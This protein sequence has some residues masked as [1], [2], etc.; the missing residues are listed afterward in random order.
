MP[1]QLRIRSSSR[2]TVTAYHFAFEVEGW[3]I[4]TIN[5]D[6]GEISIQSDWGNYA[7]RWTPKHTG[8]PSMHHFFA[9]SG[10][11]YFANKFSYENPKLKNVPDE[12]RTRKELRALIIERRKDREIGADE[13]R[14]L[15]EHVDSFVS[16]NCNLHC[17]DRELWKFLDEPWEY[18]HETKSPTYRFLVDSLLPFLQQWVRDNVVNPPKPVVKTC[19]AADPCDQC[20]TYGRPV[21]NG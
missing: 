4:L 11:D 18:V 16:E 21:S 17:M 5:D 13:A 9:K 14:G 7:H 10:P 2:N 8:C 3:A 20:L 15:W 6:T 1:E 19:T 12:E